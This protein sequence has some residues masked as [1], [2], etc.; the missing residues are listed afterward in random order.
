MYLGTVSK[1]VFWGFLGPNVPYLQTAKDISTNV[2]KKTIQRNCITLVSIDPNILDGSR[3]M[4]NAPTYFMTS[5][6][7]P[8]KV[9]QPRYSI[10]NPFSLMVFAH[11]FAPLPDTISR[12]QWHADDIH[13]DA[14]IA[15]G[16]G[17]D[18]EVSLEK[19]KGRSHWKERK[20]ALFSVNRKSICSD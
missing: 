2:N 19:S 14:H 13:F 4:T 16:N 10:L 7:T 12:C 20:I 6:L 8:R 1:K 5:H 18:H 11:G 9:Q 17:K 15:I 3:K